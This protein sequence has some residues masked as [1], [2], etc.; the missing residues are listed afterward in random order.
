MTFGNV[1]GLGGGLTLSELF[2]FDATHLNAQSGK[3]MDSWGIN[4]FMK[5][6]NVGTLTMSIPEPST[7]GLGLGAL[8]LAFAAI[9]RRQA[10]AKQ[11]VA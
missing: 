2:T 3:N 8:A 10:K 11:E 7:Y 6:D 5:Y 1:T 9:R 4:A